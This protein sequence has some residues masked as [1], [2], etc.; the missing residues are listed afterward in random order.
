[1]NWVLNPCREC[2]K[3]PNYITPHHAGGW[4]YQHHIPVALRPLLGGKTAIVRYI[5]RMPRREAEAIARSFAVMDAADVA[6]YWEVTKKERAALAAFGGLPA[7]LNNDDIPTS[8]LDERYAKLPNRE[9]FWR[10]LQAES[11]LHAVDKEPSAELAVSW[12]ALL[13]QWI[14]IKA[15]TRIRGHEATIALLKEFFG[16]TI[17]CRKI[18]PSEIGQFRDKL[19]NEGVSR[20]M[21][22]T[23]LK[24]IRAMFSAASQEPTDNP[25]YGIINPAT[26]VNVLGKSPPQRDGRDRA[27]TRSQVRTVLET[28][29]RIR[30]G[31]S[32][33][34]EILWMLRLLA[35][36]GA[37]PNEIAQLQGGDVYEHDGVKL[38]HIRN[39][40]AITDQPHRQK[41]VKMGEGRL[42]PLHPD[43]IGFFDYSATFPKDVFIFGSF[44]WNKDNGRAAGLITSFSRFLR[45]DCQIVDATKR[46]TL[47]SLRH[48]FHDAMDEADIPEKQQHRLVGHRAKNIHARYGGGEL[49]L[50]AR[51]M[52]SIKPTG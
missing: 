3:I 34:E 19:T 6:R 20:E 50:L 29:A 30:L 13:A 25:F 35:F 15:P 41:S 23:R 51:H 17:D 18:T 16:E 12:D 44:P 39:T 14:R 24:R 1:L 26:G 28:A 33:H 2:D 45:A 22:A 38:I 9:L 43:V 42:V 52:A 37:R 36:S 11:I 40:D 46:L 4:R 31:G 21:V 48:R 49:R 7:L 10:R 5:K 47:Y 8:V 27:F 32:R